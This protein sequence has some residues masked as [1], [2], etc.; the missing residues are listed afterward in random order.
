[1]SHRDRPKGYVGP[2]E[3]AGNS[4]EGT[5]KSAV[6]WSEAPEGLWLDEQKFR[7]GDSMAKSAWA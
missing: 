6:Q 7:V 5:L 2:R 3:H 1:M 4:Y